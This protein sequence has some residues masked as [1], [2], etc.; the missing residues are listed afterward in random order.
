MKTQTPI[1]E[2]IAEWMLNK[3]QG[4][5]FSK[6]EIGREIYGALKSELGDKFDA[7]M[8]IDSRRVS[9]IITRARVYLE[10]TRHATIVTMIKQGYKIANPKEATIY[11]V[12]TFKRMTKAAETAVRRGRLIRK[13]LLG[14]PELK[15]DIETTNTSLKQLAT[16]RERLS[17]VSQ[18]IGGDHAK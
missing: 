16:Y 7:S 12:K 4:K 15:K 10:E 17:L 13:E 9:E 5:I 18:P 14:S 6:E 11:G 1:H 2:E 3:A 8:K